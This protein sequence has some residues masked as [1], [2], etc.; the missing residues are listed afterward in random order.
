VSVVLTLA[1]VLLPQTKMC[2]V[3]VY[4]NDGLKILKILWKQPVV[5]TD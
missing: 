2:V 5:R 1:D 3:L 4:I